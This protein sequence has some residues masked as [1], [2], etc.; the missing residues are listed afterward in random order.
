MAVLPVLLRFPQRSLPQ[1]LY[2]EGELGTPVIWLSRVAK[3]GRYMAEE[4]KQR[5]AGTVSVGLPLSCP[6]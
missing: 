4:E 3:L 1:R 2:G 5:P 6:G